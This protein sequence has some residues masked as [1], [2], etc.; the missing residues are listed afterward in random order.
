MEEPAEE[1]LDVAPAQP[2]SHEHDEEEPEETP[3]E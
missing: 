2:C 3:A 1:P